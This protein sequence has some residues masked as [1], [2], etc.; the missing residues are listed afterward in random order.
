[1]SECPDCQ[2]EID[3]LVYTDNISGT[4]WGSFSIGDDGYADYDEDDREIS[5]SETVRF[6][7]PECNTELF[8][9][10]REA[11]EFLIGSQRKK[12][13]TT[14][15]FRCDKHNIGFDQSC[16]MCREVPDA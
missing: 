8:H 11:I 9:R 6:E 15:L 3:H 12:V 14:Y 2:K 1:M 5:E 16:P 13:K 7:C 4:S 10:E